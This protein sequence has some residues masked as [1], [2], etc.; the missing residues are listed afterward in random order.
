MQI[1]KR[2]LSST[3]SRNQCRLIQKRQSNVFFISISNVEDVET[4]KEIPI[5]TSSVVHRQRHNFCKVERLCYMAGKGK[6]LFFLL[7]FVR[8]FFIFHL[9]LCS[10]FVL[11]SKYAVW[12]LFARLLRLE[13][14]SMF[15]STVIKQ[16]HRLVVITFFRSTPT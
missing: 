14:K 4:K 8:V 7:V 12:F 2:L 1:Y 16:Q 15:C 10:L 6:I 9:N 11:C 13:I 3:D 5:G